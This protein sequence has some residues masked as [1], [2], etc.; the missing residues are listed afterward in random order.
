[1]SEV[2]QAYYDGHRTKEQTDMPRPPHCYIWGA[3]ILAL[4]KACEGKGSHQAELQILA[5]HAQKVNTPLDLQQYVHVC[6]ISSAYLDG[7]SKISIAT[8]P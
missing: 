4:P 6:K 2:G 5:N 1:M 3:L 8:N 7:W